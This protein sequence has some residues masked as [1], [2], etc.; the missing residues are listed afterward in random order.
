MESIFSVISCLSHSQEAISI[1]RV[2]NAIFLP[3][4][5]PLELL[6]QDLT[7]KQRKSSLRFIKTPKVHVQEALSIPSKIYKLSKQK[8]GTILLILSR[9]NFE[10]HS[11][12]NLFLLLAILVLI[13]LKRAARTWDMHLKSIKVCLEIKSQLDHT[14]IGQWKTLK[15]LH[16]HSENNNLL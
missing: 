11:D 10:S 8:R 2:I 7:S 1:P 9:N 4:K 3:F 12:N 5:T 16:F 15:C 14:Q 13:L 6:Q